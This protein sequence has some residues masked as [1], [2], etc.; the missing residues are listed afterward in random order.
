MKYTLNILVILITII[1]IYY[2]FTGYLDPIYNK[3]G[4]YS[5]RQCIYN[6]NYKKFNGKII[7]EI[8]YVPGIKVEYIYKLKKYRCI[9]PDTNYSKYENIT[10]IEIYANLN[11]DFENRQ[12][13]LCYTCQVRPN[14]SF[15]NSN[16]ESESE[17]LLKKIY[18][19]I[20]VLSLLIFFIADWILIVNISYMVPYEYE[21]Y[22]KFKLYIFTKYKIVQK[23]I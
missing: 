12:E 10:N 4:E 15:T 21:L 18:D 8:M 3:I 7:K 5:Y 6:F 23:M 19:L 9:I 16:F 20:R 13:K 17:G 2:E 22:L 1:L 11:F 14:L